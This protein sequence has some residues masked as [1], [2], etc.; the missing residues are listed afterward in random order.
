MAIV[1]SSVMINRVVDAVYAALTNLENHKQLGPG[2][3]DIVLN[4][5]LAVG[6]R[7]VIK[8]QA[9]GR[10]FS[11]ENEITA[12]EPGKKM[13]IKTLAAPPASPVTNTYTLE[14]AGDGTKLT[15]AMDAVI[16]PGTEGM[17][18]PQLQK[19]LDASNAAWKRILEG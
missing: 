15:L 19:A 6:A 2:I 7:Y 17:V 3:T 4:G 13:A 1:E 18:R 12:L 11:T 5:P 14:P 9:Y 10:S 8:T 16:F